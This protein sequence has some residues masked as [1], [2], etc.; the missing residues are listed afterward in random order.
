[1]QNIVYRLIRA[2][3]NSATHSTSKSLSLMQHCLYVRMLTEQIS[4]VLIKVQYFTA[5]RLIG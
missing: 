2:D 1:M 5:R 3:E 4:G